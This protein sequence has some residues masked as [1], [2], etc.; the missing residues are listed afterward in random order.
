[1]AARAAVTI[2]WLV[3]LIDSARAG[4]QTPMGLAELDIPRLPA[5]LIWLSIAAIP[6]A[7]VIS[8]WV[9]FSQ[10]HLVMEDL[11]FVTAFI[12]RRFGPGTYSHGCRLLRPAMLSIVTSLLAGVVTGLSTWLHPSQADIAAYLIAGLLMSAGLGI[13]SAWLLSRRYPPRLE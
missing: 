7:G 4:W 8:G 12:D 13:F 1:M 6:G 9:A 3:F 10:R 5:W 2:I 11:P